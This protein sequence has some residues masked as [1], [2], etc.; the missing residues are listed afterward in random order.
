MIKARELKRDVAYGLAGIDDE[1]D[2]MTVEEFAAREGYSASSIRTLLMRD[3][4]P[5]GFKVGKT[6]FLPEK[7]EIIG[8]RYNTKKRKEAFPV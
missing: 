5:R 4:I 7:A 8:K 3:K 2:L 1:E 6:W